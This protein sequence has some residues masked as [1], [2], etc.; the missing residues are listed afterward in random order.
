MKMLLKKDNL[1]KCFYFLCFFVFCICDQRIGSASGEIQLICPNIVLIVLSCIALSHYPLY[2]FR[3]ISFLVLSL[4]CGMGAALVLYFGWPKTYYPYQLLSGVIAAVLYCF[5]IMQTA[6]TIFSRK[7][8]PRSNSLGLGLL[9]LLVVLMLLSRHDRYMGVL[10]C[11]SVVLIYLTDFTAQECEWML[12]ALGG[13]VLAAFFVLQSLA[14]VFR[15]Y[16]TPR[17]LGMYANTNMNALLYQIV[18]CVF[19]GSFCIWEVKK[20]HPVLKWGSFCFACAMW[21]FVLLTMCRSAFLGMAAATLLGCGIT[22]WKQRGKCLQKALVYICGMILVSVLSFPV[23]YGAVRYLPAVFHH[24]IW[25]MTEYSE[26]KVHSWDPYDSEKYTDWHEILHENFGRLFLN[27]TVSEIPSRQVTEVYPLLSAVQFFSAPT[28][29]EAPAASEPTPSP[30]GGTPVKSGSVSARF[31]IYR[32]Y[33]S[34]LISGDMLTRKTESRGARVTWPRS[35]ELLINNLCITA[36][37]VI[38]YL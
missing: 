8:L 3:R 36:T 27:I 13:A 5:V 24:P 18:Y 32:H 38:L 25:F 10:L 7:S 15:P 28:V 19:L 31:T 12:K 2:S 35:K 1:K 17:Y 30:E 20:S 26:E 14:F 11:F 16:D 23:V 4:V 34:Q 22:L 21:S 29:E 9:S 6:F 33:L 37:S